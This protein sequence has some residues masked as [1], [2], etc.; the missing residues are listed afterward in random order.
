M[1]AGQLHDKLMQ[2]GATV[3]VKSLQAI[4]SGKYTPVPQGSSSTKIAP[5]IFTPDCVLDWNQKS[6]DVYNKI[7][8]LSPYPGAITRL[9]GKIFKIYAAS[10]TL[11]ESDLQP[12]EIVSDGKQFVKFRT[13]DGFIYTT[14]IQLEGKKRIFVEEFL[15]GNKLS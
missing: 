7:R 5:K 2:V 1:N 14:E 10:Y 6:I 9:N 13:L 15:K 3:I 8:G 4:D 11:E 12:G